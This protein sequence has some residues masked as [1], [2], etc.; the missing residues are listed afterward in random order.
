MSRRSKRDKV[1]TASAAAAPVLETLK[2]RY[3]AARSQVAFTAPFYLYPLAIAAAIFVFVSP[4]ETPS[5]SRVCV[6]GVAWWVALVTRKPL[7]D[8]LRR[9]G[10]LS[11]VASLVVASALAETLVRVLCIHVYP[12]G[13]ATHALSFAFG[14]MAVDSLAGI[15]SLYTAILVLDREDERAAEARRRLEAQGAPNPLLMPPWYSLLERIGESSL[16][17]GCAL[18]IAAEPQFTAHAF[19]AQAL[20]TYAARVHFKGSPFAT[21]ALAVF[22][23]LVLWNSLYWNGFLSGDFLVLK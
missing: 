9:T 11:N 20:G 22:G 5:V 13:A 21:E 6:G 18:L 3:A 17:C 2:Q 15:L 8:L 16:G 14:W 10:L 4:A 1:A 12:G 7:A 19:T 23:L